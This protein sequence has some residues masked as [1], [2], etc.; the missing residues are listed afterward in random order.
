MVFKANLK[1]RL[2]DMPEW[3]IDLFYFGYNRV[4][5]PD[6]VEKKKRYGMLN[7]DSTFYVIRP[8][9]DSVEGLMSLLLYVCEQISYAEK[10]GWI[11]VV[12]FQNYK[13]QYN[14]SDG[15][16][17]WE[18]FFKQLNGQSLNAVYQS[19]KV[20]LSGINASRKAESYFKEKSVK[21]TDIK[22]VHALFEKYIRCSDEVE[23][24]LMQE[25]RKIVPERSLG[26]YLR[27]TD[28]VKLRPTGEAVQ[29]TIE[30]ALEVA[31]KY[32]EQFDLNKV[33]LVTEDAQVYEK[34]FEHYKDKLMITS[35]DVFI[36]KYSAKKFL[37]EDDAIK[38]LG[39]S[40]YTRGINYLTKIKLLSEC[41][42]IVGGKTCGSWAACAFASSQTKKYIFELGNY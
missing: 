41:K 10:K 28:Y 27:G 25:K 37:A 26:L 12:D 31:D 5:Y 17:S 7:P 32:M 16:N 14:C 8:R 9:R 29:P 1:K 42:C 22:K 35:F 13:T 24:L 21:E 18:I 3:A 11:P 30:Q 36:S 15:K 38:E 2:Y 33:F 19:K 4:K 39:E 23:K 40:P 20:V 34:V 6:L